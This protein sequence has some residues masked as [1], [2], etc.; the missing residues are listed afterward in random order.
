M[1]R[2]YSRGYPRGY[3]RGYTEWLNTQSSNPY[4]HMTPRTS[5]MGMSDISPLGIVVPP[6][7]VAQ[8]F[9]ANKKP[10]AASGDWSGV[11]KVGAVVG[12]GLLGY[13]VLSHLMVASRSARG[14]FGGA[15]QVFVGG[16]E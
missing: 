1:T 6:I 14:A 9:G 4:A 15:K 5:V 12:V 2:G 11:L 8:L 7:G 16:D 13:F 10:V 3:P